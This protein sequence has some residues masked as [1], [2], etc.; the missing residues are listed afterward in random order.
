MSGWQFPAKRHRIPRRGHHFYIFCSPRP[1][2]ADWHSSISSSIICLSNTD[3]RRAR[4]P[5]SAPP[6]LTTLPSP[7]IPENYMENGREYHGFRKGKYMF[8]CDEVNLAGLPWIFNHLPRRGETWADCGEIY[9]K[10]RIAWISTTNS[11]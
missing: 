1:S 6:P 2:E 7:L 5:L 11:S 10:K 4:M 8:P 9:S 3:L